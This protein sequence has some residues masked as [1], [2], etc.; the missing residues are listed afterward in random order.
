[1]SGHF[2]E[3]FNTPQMFHHTGLSYLTRATSIIKTIQ[4]AEQAS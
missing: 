2:W 1:M 3:E 4:L